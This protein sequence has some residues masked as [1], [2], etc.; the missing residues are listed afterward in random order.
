[1]VTVFSFLFLAVP[2]PLATAMQ[3]LL[4]AVGAE[5]FQALVRYRHVKGTP[6]PTAGTF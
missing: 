3:Y 1:M 2:S 5:A 4:V 6:L